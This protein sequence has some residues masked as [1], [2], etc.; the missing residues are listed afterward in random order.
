M[1]REL[2]LEASSTPADSPDLAFFF[3]LGGVQ[4]EV[5]GLRCEGQVTATNGKADNRA[6]S[7]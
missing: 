3:F 7:V 6:F 2:R 5:P 4:L 1:R